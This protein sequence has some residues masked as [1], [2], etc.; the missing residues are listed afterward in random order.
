L[1]EARSQK[2]TAVIVIETSYDRR[3]PSYESWW[4][5]PVAEVSESESV[6]SARTKYVQAREK[7]RIF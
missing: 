1:I 4:D 3:V 6:Q 5:V 7:E 2:D